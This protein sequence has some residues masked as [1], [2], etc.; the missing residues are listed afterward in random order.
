MPLLETKLRFMLNSSQ[1]QVVILSLN[2]AIKKNIVIL[3]RKVM[4]SLLIL[5]SLWLSGEESA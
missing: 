4:Y 1:L 2:S 3:V 5:G